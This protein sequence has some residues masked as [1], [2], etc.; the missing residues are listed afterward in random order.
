MELKFERKKF[1]HFW[2]VFPVKNQS[3]AC[4]QKKY[5]SKLKWPCRFQIFSPE[6]STV[7]L[8]KV[9]AILIIFCILFSLYF[10][11]RSTAYFI[12]NV[13]YFIFLYNYR[14][15]SLNSGVDF[16]MDVHDHKQRHGLCRLVLPTQWPLDGL[17]VLEA[18]RQNTAWRKENLR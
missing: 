16:A 8:S 4:M 13:L 3:W 10:F 11:S 1:G 18:S 2:P 7:K 14:Q 17:P 15:P 12:N 5:A 6:V 9:M